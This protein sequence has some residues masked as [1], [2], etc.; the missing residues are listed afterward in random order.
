MATSSASQNSTVAILSA[1]AASFFF[2]FND[3]AIKFLSGDYALHQV[4]LVRSLVGMTL[5]LVFIL[6]F[7]GGLAVLKTKRLPIH[8]LRGFCVVVANMTFFLGLAAMPLAD[9]VAVFFVAPLIITALSVFFLGETV[10]PRRWLAVGV[11]MLGVLVMLRPGQ[12]SFQVAALLP[13]IAACAYALI[14]ILTRKIG[15]TE[16]A[17]T[18]IFYIQLTFILVSAAIGLA[19]GNGRFAGWDDPSLDF[20]FRAWSWPGTDDYVI[21]LLIGAASTGGGYFISQAYRLGEAA[22]IAPFEYVAMLLAIFWGV[23]V[24]GTL[25]DGIAWIGIALIVGSG[26]FVFWREALVQRRVSARLPLR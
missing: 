8:L 22:L 6:P 7:Q 24:F 5:L 20:M 17:I 15:G 19:L 1:V 12:G 25:P 3:M 26:V 16:R 10:G 4:V 18:M 11:G 23:A 13:L 2:S 21:F 9:A 14:H